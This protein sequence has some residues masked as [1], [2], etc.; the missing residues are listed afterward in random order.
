M[1]GSSIHGNVT[2]VQQC[3]LGRQLRI[4]KSLYISI[5]VPETEVKLK[6]LP[7]SC[8]LE[9]LKTWPQAQPQPASSYKALHKTKQDKRT[10]KTVTWAIWHQPQVL[11]QKMMLPHLAEVEKEWKKL[12]LKI[13]GRWR[14]SNTWKEHVLQS[15][16]I[17]KACSSKPPDL[18]QRE[19]IHICCWGYSSSSYA[20]R[21]E[22]QEKV[23]WGIHPWV[24]TRAG[25]TRPVNAASG[26]HMWS[27]VCQT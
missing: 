17:Y 24:H 26:T 15:K 20:W 9:V 7:H 21:N 11:I 27:R 22:M 8:P 19:G 1:F 10:W 5:S 13:T 12:L 23:F 2:I 6:E 14:F 3:C 25:H 16:F 4:W 18:G